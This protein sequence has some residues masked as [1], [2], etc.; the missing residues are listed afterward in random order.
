[1]AAELNVI[2]YF[3]TER[4]AKIISNPKGGGHL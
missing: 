2:A 3:P 4:R 1:M